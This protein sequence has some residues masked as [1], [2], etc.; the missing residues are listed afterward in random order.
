MS[1][2]LPDLYTLTLDALELGLL[3]GWLIKEREKAATDP[4]LADL[5]AKLVRAA[6]GEPGG[7][8]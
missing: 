8:R 5:R 6:L 7:E 1:R 2:D 4:V 3:W